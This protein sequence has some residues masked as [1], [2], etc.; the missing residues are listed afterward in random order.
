MELWK[1]EPREIKK[2]IIIITF[3]GLLLAGEDGDG[4]KKKKKDF[5]FIFGRT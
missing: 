3:R 4:I 1:L 2:I 5:K